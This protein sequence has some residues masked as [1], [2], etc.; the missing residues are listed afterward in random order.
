MPTPYAQAS[1]AELQRHLADLT[2]HDHARVRPYGKHL[3]IQ[4]HRDD[5]AVDTVARLT[6]V[7]RNS[8]TAAFRSHTGRWEPLPAAGDLKRAADLVATLLAP[9]LDPTK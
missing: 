7:A 1:A 2:G 9:Y 5:D 6:E 4:M 3:L 8:Y